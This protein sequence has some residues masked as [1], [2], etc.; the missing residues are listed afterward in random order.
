MNINYDTASYVIKGGIC[1]HNTHGYFKSLYIIYVYANVCAIALVINGSATSLM[2]SN[3][4]SSA[5]I[6]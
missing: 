1:L 6:L 3:W 2:A 5:A 4:L